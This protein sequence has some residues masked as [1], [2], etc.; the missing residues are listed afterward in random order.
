MPALLT[1]PKGHPGRRLGSMVESLILAA[2]GACI[3]VAWA[4]LATYVGS[5]LHESNVPGMLAVRAVFVTVA[6]FVH[7]YV[8]SSTPRLFIMVLLMIF[9]VLIGLVRVVA[10]F[11]RDRDRD[12]G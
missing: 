8:R 11:Q 4:S 3:G 6:L 5:L 7:G 12:W 10:L 9:P 2:I 1:P